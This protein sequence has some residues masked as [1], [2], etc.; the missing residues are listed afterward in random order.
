[1]KKD[2]IQD[3]INQAKDNTQTNVLQNITPIK[4]IIKNEIQF[5]FYIDKMLLK[6]LKQKSLNEDTTVKQIVVNAIKK[7]LE[8]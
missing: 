1:M 7:Y 5:S 6:E 2:N 3:L 4:N 8:K